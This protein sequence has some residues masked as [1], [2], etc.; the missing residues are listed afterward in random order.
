M[1][2]FSKEDFQI[3]DDKGRNLQGELKL[4]EPRFRKERPSLYAGKI[5]PYTGRRIPGPPEDKRVLY[6]ELVYPFKQKPSSLTFIPPLDEKFKMSTVAIGFI[7]YH[8]RV[9]INDF[10]YLSEP[11]TV[12]L[13]WDDPWY[14]EFDK[15]ALKRWQRGG[16]MSFLYIEPYEV[17]KCGMRS[18]LG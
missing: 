7:T 16:V 18:L 8:N 10:R 9:P 12:T 1:R 5:N 13:D 3:V 11:S 17:M 15:K 14:S 6:A 2:L 4:I